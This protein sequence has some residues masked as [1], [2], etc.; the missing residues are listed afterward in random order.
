MNSAP[1]AVVLPA[2]SDNLGV[3]VQVVHKAAAL[4]PVGE[5]ETQA[6]PEAEEVLAAS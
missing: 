1:L 6:T 4:K 3:A 5:H 2:P